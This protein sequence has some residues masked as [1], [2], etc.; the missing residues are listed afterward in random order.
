MEFP[1]DILT[2]IRAYSR[3][4]FRHWKI[5]N[6]AKRVVKHRYWEP[7]CSDLK[8]IKHKLMCPNAEQLSEILTTY[9]IDLEHIYL[10]EETLRASKITYGIPRNQDIPEELMDK[11]ADILELRRDAAIKETSQYEMLVLQLYGN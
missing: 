4:R 7:L 2:L 11:L 8:Y 3:P 5:F 10:C 9:L 6:E 1:E